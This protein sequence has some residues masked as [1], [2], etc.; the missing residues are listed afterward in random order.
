M[1][2]VVEESGTDEEELVC[3]RGATSIIWKWFGFQRSDSQQST[4]FRRQCKHV[5]QAKGGNTSNLF[6]HL[7]QRHMEKYEEAS[8]LR[9]ATAANE[10]FKQ[11]C[12]FL[13]I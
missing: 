12:F 13:H 2:G 7:K 4:V 6:H 11:L 1:A 3:K 9:D 8:K 10:Y 5:V